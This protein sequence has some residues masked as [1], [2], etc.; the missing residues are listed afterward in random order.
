MLKIRGMSNPAAIACMITVKGVAGTEGTCALGWLG[1]EER[2]FIL[3]RYSI[4]RA[5]FSGS[6]S[7]FLPY[8]SH[9]T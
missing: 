7:V 9:Y 3:G 1:C 2:L 4:T 5:V 8:I 6:T